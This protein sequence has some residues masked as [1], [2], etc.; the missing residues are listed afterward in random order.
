MDEELGLVEKRED[1]VKQV[2]MTHDFGKHIIVTHGNW[3]KTHTDSWKC[4]IYCENNCYG[5][6]YIY[7]KLD[8]SEIREVK[9]I[10]INNKM[11]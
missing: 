11:I 5:F 7:F 2:F 3:E 1:Q 4:K 8:S 10:S 9:F 6:L